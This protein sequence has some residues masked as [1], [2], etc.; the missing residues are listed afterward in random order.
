MGLSIL[1]LVFAIK[2]SIGN[3]TEIITLLDKDNYTRTEIAENYVRLVSRWGEWIIVGDNG[4]LFEISFVN[5]GNALFSGLM[6]TYVILTFV[7]FTSSIVIGKFIFPNLSE[8]FKAHNQDMVNLATLDTQDLI[9]ESI[10]V[11]KTKKQEEWF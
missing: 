1:F 9:K 11:K 7:S 4:T 5:I 6:K 10:A 2:N 8:Y 3:V